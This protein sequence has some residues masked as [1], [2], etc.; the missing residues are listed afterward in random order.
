MQK[1]FEGRV[2]RLYPPQLVLHAASLTIDGILHTFS[3][4][5]ILKEGNILLANHPFFISP[6][7][8]SSSG[9]SD[10][11]ARSNGNEVVCIG[12]CLALSLPLT[13]FHAGLAV[14]AQLVSSFGMRASGSSPYQVPSRGWPPN[15]IAFQE[16]RYV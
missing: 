2:D 14:S 1:T 12:H 5:N 6:R 11:C 9:K 7:R 8:L 15:G 3:L 10:G 16:I 13:P 4:M